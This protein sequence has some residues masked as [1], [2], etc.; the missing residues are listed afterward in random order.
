MALEAFLSHLL[1]DAAELREELSASLAQAAEPASQEMRERIVASL[2]EL[3]T[4]RESIPGKVG[5]RIA[6]EYAQSLD[7]LLRAS[8]GPEGEPANDCVGCTNEL[9]AHEASRSVAVA[10][11]VE[12]RRSALRQAVKEADEMKT[13]IAA[14]RTAPNIAALNDKAAMLVPDRK[15]D[16]ENDLMALMQ[17]RSIRTTGNGSSAIVDRKRRQR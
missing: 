10:A 6:E 1:P 9:L 8:R 15:D 5:L 17:N 4:Q 7:A 2:G 16:K 14:L 3:Q 12:E 11:S 13:Q